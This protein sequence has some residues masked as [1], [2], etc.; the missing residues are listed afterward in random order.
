MFII[1]SLFKIEVKI[2]HF[3]TKFT[4]FRTKTS[5]RKFIYWTNVIL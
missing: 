4:F 2:H 1:F 3:K 5:N